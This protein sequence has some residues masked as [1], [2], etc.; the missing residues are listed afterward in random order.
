M[1]GLS[2][3]FYRQPD[4]SMYDTGGCELRHAS[5]AHMMCTSGT[6]ASS[7]A[8][9]GTSSDNI[10]EGTITFGPGGRS[11]EIDG[12]AATGYTADVRIDRNEIWYS[13]DCPD[14]DCHNG[15]QV[16]YTLTSVPESAMEESGRWLDMEECEWL[17]VLSR[18]S[19]GA[20]LLRTSYATSDAHERDYK[21]SDYY[22]GQ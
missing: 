22:S 7:C 8:A 3:C 1:Y 13:S 11:G 17:V 20:E 9:V 10:Y 14:Y 16:C 4:P 2:D 15:M 18:S 6:D 21:F 12:A 19:D 5:R